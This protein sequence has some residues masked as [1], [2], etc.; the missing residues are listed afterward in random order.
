G[1][2]ALDDDRTDF[3]PVELRREFLRPGTLYA[4]PFGHTLIIVKWVPQTQEH[5]GLLLAVDAQPDN[6]VTRKRFWEG[7]FLFAN[8]VPSAGPG[9]KY[10]RPL[11]ATESGNLQL[12]TNLSLAADEEFVP[13]S[14]EQANLNAESFYAR[15]SKLI[16][17]AGLEPVKAYETMLDALVEQ[18]ET[19]VTS[20]DNGEQYLR[21]NSKAVIPMPDGAAI[22]Q[23]AGPWED[24]ATPSRDLRLI[25]AIN[26]LQS[27]ADRILRY[28]DLFKLNSRAPE[29]AK[30]EVEKLHAHRIEERGITYTRSDGGATRLTVA[31]IL[32]RKAALEMAYNPNDCV[33]VRWGAR[34]ETPEYAS[35]KRHAPAAQ[36]VKMEKYRDWFRNAKRP[37]L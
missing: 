36:R 37:S 20:V 25:I 12:L 10:F 17:P 4:D 9:F 3:Y 35:C 19:R 11:V 28:P 34:E 30:A 7:T 22:F 23:T 27:L 33:E 8:D 14:I 32:A 5:S 1:R 2:T 21:N 6:S 24:Y 18:L 31:D 29:A 15:M 16:N 13:Y 26:I